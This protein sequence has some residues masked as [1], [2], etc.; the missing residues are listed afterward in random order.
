MSQFDNTGRRGF[1]TKV[2]SVAGTV[3]IAGCSGGGSGDGSSDGG[4]GDGSS[5]D[6]SGDGGSTEEPS[7]EEQSTDSGGSEPEGTFVYSRA[8]H[9]SSLDFMTADAVSND[10]IKV[11]MSVYDSVL[12]F[13]P[14]TATLTSGLATDWEVSETT[15]SLTLREGVTFHNG[16]EFSA[17]DVVATY[18]RYTDSDY[19]YFVENVTEGTQNGY[20]GFTYGLVSDVTKEGEYEVT[21]ELSQPFAPILRNLAMWSAAVLPQSVIEAETDLTK[22]AIG[23]G[24]FELDEVDD[25]NQRVFLQAREGGWYKEGPFVGEVIFNAIQENSTRVQSL[26]NGESQLVDGLTPTTA[27]QVQNGSGVELRRKVGGNVGNIAMNLGTRE[28]LRDDR[29][30]QAIKYAV[31]TQTI[32]EEIY[33]GYARVGTQPSPPVMLGFNEELDPYPHDPDQAQSLLEEAGYG[34]GFSLELATF[35]NPRAYHPAPLQTAEVARS[36]LGDV[37][38]EVEINQMPFGDW[39]SY[40]VEGNHELIQSGWVTD[41]ADPDNILYTLLDPGLPVEE[42]P[43]DQN[44]VDRTTSGYNQFNFAAWYDEEFVQNVRDGRT[45]YDTEQRREFYREANRIAHERGPW[46]T[47]GYQELL[48]GVA[49]NVSNYNVAVKVNENLQTVRLD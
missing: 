8:N 39:F 48:R 47:Y 24:P 38:I 18:R 35:Q 21:M 10:N 22:D 26:I 3:A 5:D 33:Q 34:D 43:E 32:I 37:G 12:G 11:L 29:V 19:D 49:E 1:L 28:E 31:D 44:W 42:L 16:D 40:G 36:N 20:A 14:G 25:G 2:G 7:T 4:S 6:E 17:D 15:V 30:R 46:V 41:N 45:T 23:T 27:A 13:E 9:I